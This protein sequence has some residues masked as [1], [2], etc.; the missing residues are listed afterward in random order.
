MD[1]E[2]NTGV[3]LQIVGTPPKI[4]MVIGAALAFFMLIYHHVDMRLSRTSL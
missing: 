2:I 4:A 1:K 3:V